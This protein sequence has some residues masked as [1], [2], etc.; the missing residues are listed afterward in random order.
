M[1]MWVDLASPEHCDAGPGSLTE[2]GAG[3][4]PKCGAL[5]LISGQ[6]SND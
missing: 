2:I 1:T 6:L 4:A 5:F 3:D